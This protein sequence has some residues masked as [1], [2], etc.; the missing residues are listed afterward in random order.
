MNDVPSARGCIASYV[1][2]D[3]DERQNGHLDKSVKSV[4][5]PKELIKDAHRTVTPQSKKCLNKMRSIMPFKLDAF[6]SARMIL[7]LQCLRHTGLSR[8]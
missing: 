6:A 4:K 7:E 3:D 1:C 5:V 8:G 2:F